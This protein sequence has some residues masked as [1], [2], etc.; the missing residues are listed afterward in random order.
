VRVLVQCAKRKCSVEDRGGGVTGLED[1]VVPEIGL[2]VVAGKIR[3][4]VLAEIVEVSPL[5]GI[6]DG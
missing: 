3:D 2:A 1:N 4:G 6:L 5:H